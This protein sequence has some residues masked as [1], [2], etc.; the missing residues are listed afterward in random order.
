MEPSRDILLVDDDAEPRHTLAATLRGAGYAVRTAGS[1]RAALVSARGLQPDLILAAS[2]L[3]D[4]GALELLR[5]VKADQDIATTPVIT[6]ARGEDPDEVTRAFNAGSDD[7]LLKPVR[8]PELLVRVRAHLRLRRTVEE[9]ARK[10]RDAQ[11]LLELTRTLASS[12]DFE[13]ILHTVVRRIAEAV[14]VERA[15]LVLA[16]DAERGDVAFVVATS[17][18]EQLSNLELDL[19]KYPEIQQV[20]RSRAPLTIA[21]ASIHPLLDGVRKDLEQ[22]QLRAMSLFPVVWEDKAI[23]VLFLRAQQERGVLDEREEH[24]CRVVSNATALALR[25]ARMMQSLRN[26]TQRVTFARFEAERRLRSLKRYADLFSS[27][28]D[29]IAVIAADGRLLFC[30]PRGYELVGREE[31]TLRGQVVGELVHPD[32]RAEATELWRGF[33]AGH[34]P[35]AVDLRIRHGDGHYVVCNSSFA[36]LSGGDDTVLMSFRDVTDERKTEAEL[37]KTKEFL[38]SLVEASVDAIIAADLRGRIILFNAGA[39]SILG[40]RAT[41]VLGKMHVRDLYLDDGAKV[42]MAKLR[43]DRHGGPGRLGPTRIDLRDRHGDR[44]PV[45]LAA[46]TIR[47]QGK[48]VATFGIFTDLRKRLQTEERLALAQEKLLVTEKQALLAELAGA[49]AH[50][51]NQPLTSVMAYAELLTRKF[52]SSD[53][54]SRIARGMLDE[55][56]RMAEI[57]RKIGRITRYETKS[58]VGT[59]RILDLDRAADA[60]GSLHEPEGSDG[61]DGHAAVPPREARQK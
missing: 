51:L 45:S 19:N 2:E 36:P 14:R 42:V 49:T 33:K 17:D 54:A 38:E 52:A 57:V 9:L 8:L 18:D 27:A 22:T 50:E 55:S 5:Q 6:L 37:I 46:A 26:Q 3:P 7:F 53:E 44:I 12:F 60:E 23:G 30:N 39:E 4:A 48:P 56:E 25:N 35:R 59:Q 58:Y 11:V 20:L 32:G 16:P 21:N 1:A 40:Y 13:D 31:A 43:S 41:E 24:F 10:E 47:E 61:T 15:S 34:F 29:G 28:A